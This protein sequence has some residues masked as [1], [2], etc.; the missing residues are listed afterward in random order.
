LKDEG[1]A[2]YQT[3]VMTCGVSLLSLSE[4]NVFAKKTSE[5]LQLLCIGKREFSELLSKRQIDDET[6]EVISKWIDQ[7]KMYVA[8]A[9]REPNSVS[10]EYSMMYELRK[11]GKL[12]KF[13][14]VELV[15]TNTVGGNIVEQLLQRLFEEHFSASV[16]SSYVDIDVSEPKQMN[17]ILGEYM[18]KVSEKLS[19]GEPSS[20]CFA[21]LGGYKIMTA[22]GYIVGSFLGYPTAY[23]YE[24]SQIIHEIPPIP[25][26]LDDRFVQQHIDLLRRCRVDAI[27]MDELSYQEHQVISTYSSIFQQEEGYVYLTPFGEFLLEHER[28]KH[29]FETKY[30]ATKQVIKM[31][32]KDKQFSIDQIK[33][34]V[35]KLKYAERIIPDLQHEKEFEKIDQRKVKFH[36]YKSITGKVFRL[37]YQY[38]EAEDQLYANY[39]WFDHKQYEREAEKGVGLYEAYDEFQDVTHLILGNTIK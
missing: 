18:Q 5:L 9:E 27:H 39:L 31:I 28:Y 33:E 13:P 29:L 6:R 25:I 35:K 24:N 7:T 15:L 11:R 3:I 22:L 12:G 26:H 2:M 21:P 23:L 17:R 10:A 37:A 38:D 36:L 16:G 1:K 20:T 4:K 19:Q 30:F 34:L 8:E 32:E 14:R